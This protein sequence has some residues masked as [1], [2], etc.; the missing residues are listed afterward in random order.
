MFRPSIALATVLLLALSTL[1]AC[2]ASEEETTSTNL[3]AKINKDRYRTFSKAPEWPTR[4]TSDSS[5][6]AGTAE[7]Y[8]NRL[9]QEEYCKNDS[10]N[11][12][13]VGTLIVK[14]GFDGDTV[15]VIA[16]MSK[17]A[18]GVWDFAEWDNAGAPIDSGAKCLSCHKSG[19]D[20]VKGFR[21]PQDYP[22]KKSH[23]GG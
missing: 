21:F 16:A 9:F 1:S 18:E 11:S 3:W 12:W 14:E 7:I 20:Y 15:K 10:L 6:H 13:P 4:R 2:G 23:C 8:A 5:I 19:N 17:T 22:N